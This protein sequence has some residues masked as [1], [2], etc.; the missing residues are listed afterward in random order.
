M[1]FW[2][3]LQRDNET[4][5]MF[6]SISASLESIS[7][8]VAHHGWKHHNRIGFTPNRLFNFPVSINGNS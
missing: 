5:E 6:K 4:R 1:R 7:L 3:Q 8:E 2:A